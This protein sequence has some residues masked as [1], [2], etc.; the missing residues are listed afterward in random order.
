MPLNYCSLC[1]SAQSADVH[2]S[3]RTILLLKLLTKIPLKWLGILFLVTT[4]ACQYHRYLIAEKINSLPINFSISIERQREHWINREMVEEHL[5]LWFPPVHFVLFEMSR[6]D[7]FK[8]SFFFNYSFL[9]WMA[10]D[11]GHCR[12]CLG[13]KVFDEEHNGT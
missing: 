9:S 2:V 5:R 12:L 4:D 7:D 1:L 6:S 11:Y 10:A 13:F 8:D 3:I